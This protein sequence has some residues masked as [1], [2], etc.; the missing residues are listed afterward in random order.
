MGVRYL[1]RPVKPAGEKMA[2]GKRS[3]AAAGGRQGGPRAP[4]VV[5]EEERERLAEDLAY[6]CVACGREHASGGVRHDDLACA[7]AEIITLIRRAQ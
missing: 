2:A 3:R 1:R 4:V 5:T 7:E 6:F